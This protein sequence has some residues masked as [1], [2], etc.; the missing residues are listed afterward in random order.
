MVVPDW[1]S[2]GKNQPQKTLTGICPS[3]TLAV[4][5]TGT[6]SRPFC[7]SFTRIEPLKG[8]DLCE[9]RVYLG[10]ISLE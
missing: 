4:N 3:R 10:M 2:S 8:F 1:M 7:D 5:P 9:K 6:Q